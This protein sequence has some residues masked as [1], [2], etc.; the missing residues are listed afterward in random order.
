M[1]PSEAYS[2]LVRRSREMALLGSCG[3]VLGWDEQTYMPPGGAE[4]RAGQLA[5]LAGLHHQQATDPRLGDL[6]GEVEGSPVVA[7]PESPEAVNVREWRRSYDRRVKLPRSLVEELARVTSEAHPVWVKAREL[8]D[9][10]TFRPVLGTVV[11]LKRQEADCLGPGGDRYDALLDEYEPGARSADI[12]SMFDS[13]R[14]ELVRLVTA[15]LDSRVKPD[16]S[17]LDRDY[18][19]DRQRVLGELAASWIGFDFHR[20]RLDV[21]AHPFC[22]GIGPG[23]TRMTTRYDP[24]DFTE[25]FFGV[26][27]ETGH[28]LYD[29]GLDP[30]HQGTPMGDAVSLGV[31]ESQSR[32]W[33]NFVG[34]GRS[35]WDYAFPI[36]RG[37][38]PAAL[39]GVDRDAFHQAINRVEPSLIRTQADEVTYNLHILI[40]FRLE[41][42]LIGGDLPVDELPDA[43]NAAYREDLGVVPRHDAEGCLQDVHWSAG[44]FGYFPTYTLGNL[45][46]AQIHQAASRDLGGLDGPAS[47]GDHAALLGW[48]RDRIH[49]QGQRFRPPTLIERATGEPP[50]STY[51]VHALNVKYRALYAI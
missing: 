19:V 41:R 31:H 21:A 40:R 29:Q 8:R 23:D 37:L 43:W 50:S 9:F 4:H 27:H 30:E 18:P 11:A 15:V 10:E 44:L 42:A 5:L 39:G 48:L 16:A 6:L 36:A 49:R 14:P 1:N 20:G 7:D 32:L 47:R 45:F 51:L 34:R 12:A 13:L 28:G 26:L 22:S 17:L 35:F 3:S 38:F 25:S 46:A 33:E 2:E 24:R